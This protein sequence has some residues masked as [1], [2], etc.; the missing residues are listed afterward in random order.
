MLYVW[1]LAFTAY[2]QKP[3]D[4]PAWC[5]MVSAPFTM[6]FWNLSTH[7]FCCGVLA[8][9]FDFQFHSLPYKCS[10]HLTGTPLLDQIVCI[11]VWCWVV[12][13]PMLCIVWMQGTH[14]F[15]FE[16]S[17]LS[18]WQYIYIRQWREL[19]FHPDQNEQDWVVPLPLILKLGKNVSWTFLFHIL[20]RLHEVHWWFGEDHLLCFLQ[21][22]L[23]CV[24]VCVPFFYAIR[25]SHWVLL[26]N[27]VLVFDEYHVEGMKFSW[28]GQTDNIGGAILG[29][30]CTLIC[31]LGHASKLSNG[32]QR[33]KPFICLWNV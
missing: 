6:I 31:C 13:Q 26:W 8:W 14:H 10:A 18:R 29:Y 16:V 11:S 22:V 12:F 17:H 20:L 1:S 15:L 33:K 21:D 27:L 9:T 3:L 23:S 24:G 5:R 19:A 4:K 32:D 2:I 30:C 7:P 28:L 25:Y